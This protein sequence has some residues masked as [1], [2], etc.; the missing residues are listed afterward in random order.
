[1]AFSFAK[2]RI[3]VPNGWLGH[4][5]CIMR[6][7]KGPGIDLIVPLKCKHESTPLNSE[8]TSSQANNQLCECDSGEKLLGPIY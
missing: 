1:L 8:L 5:Y 6:T 7:C 4:E 2:I 3:P